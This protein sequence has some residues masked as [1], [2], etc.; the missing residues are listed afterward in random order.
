MPITAAGKFFQ[1]G[2]GPLIVTYSG[3]AS[4]T[5]NFTKDGSNLYLPT[6]GSYTFTFNRVG[7]LLIK[8]VS[9]GADG[10]S[11]GLN[12]IYAKG[13][14]GGGGGAA[15]STGVAFTINRNLTYAG[16]VGAGGSST[17]TQ[18]QIQSSTFFLQL[19]PGT[20][21]GSG[22]AGGTVAVGSG[23]V[24]GGAGGK[25]SGQIITGYDE[26]ND[27]DP[28]YNF[29]D[30]G[31]AGSSG[32]AGGG[33]GGGSD[34]T[35]AAGAGGTSSISGTNV[36]GGNGTNGTGSYQGNG[37]TGGSGVLVNGVCYGGGGGGGGAARTG[38][39]PG[40]GG[41]GKQG[42]LWFTLNE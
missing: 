3:A 31:Q 12:S 41:A 7:K 38:N 17:N 6:T 39:T 4:G 18:F 26:N 42:I 10:A 36:S 37:G 35:S 27:G 1:V 20:Y 11:G 8:G 28:I 29:G 2:L 30:P 15:H 21:G 14:N 25:G 33:G 34:V 22:G 23:G 16:I 32:A 40:D 13:G 24:A 5:W 9:A 19:T